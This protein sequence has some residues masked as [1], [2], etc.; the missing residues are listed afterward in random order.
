MDRCQIEKSD[1]KEEKKTGEKNAS[2]SF[3][4]IF[5]VLDRLWTESNHKKKSKKKKSKQMV[6]DDVKFNLIGALGIN[7]Y[8][9]K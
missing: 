9:K 3:V 8:K 4:C 6:I 5:D 1:E 7:I 2:N